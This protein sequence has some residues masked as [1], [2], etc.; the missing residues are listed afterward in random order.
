MNENAWPTT[1]LEAV[2]YFANEDRCLLFM[3]QMRWPDGVVKCPQCGRDDPR[4]L[5]NVRRWE[6]RNKH[7]RKQFS[8]KTGTIFEDSPLSLSKWLPTVWLLANDKN[9]IS[10]YEAHRAIGVTQKTAW[11]MLSRIRLAMQDGGFMMTGT[12]EA[13]ETFIGGKAKY[14]HQDKRAQRIRHGRGG[15]DK[16]MVVG[17]LERHGQPNSRVKATVKADRTR[18]SL[19]PFIQQNVAKGSEVFTDSLGSYRGL[20][21][22]YVHAFVDHAERYVEGRVHT[23]GLENFWALLKRAINGTY[24]SVESFHLFRYVDE[25]AFRFN[26]RKATDGQRRTKVLGSVTGR[27]LTYKQLIGKTDLDIAKG[28]ASV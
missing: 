28:A 26:T 21:P 17:L 14:M 24:V 3:V 20:E 8:I 13:D 11:F 7:P 16:A 9:G 15:N 12:V 18:R 1:L 5:A 2:N 6:C 4:F 23:N 27:R 22:D 25:E 10:S 19:H